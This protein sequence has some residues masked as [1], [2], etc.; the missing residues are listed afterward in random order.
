MLPAAI[1]A[2]MKDTVVVRVLEGEDAYGAPQYG[3]AM[4]VQ[5]RVAYEKQAVSTPQGNDI[6]VTTKVYMDDIPTLTAGSEIT[7]PDGVAHNVDTF[8]RPAWPN[9]SRHLEIVL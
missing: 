4:R 3:T 9:G 2:Q 1:R 5:C 8:F 7:T 6:V